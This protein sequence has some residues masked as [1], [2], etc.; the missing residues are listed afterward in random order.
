MSPD[1]LLA[2]PIIASSSNPVHG[3]RRA[4]HENA[5][6]GGNDTPCSATEAQ[7]D[8]SLLAVP[9]VSVLATMK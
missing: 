7:P 6:T 2:H 8:A 4:C 9:T 5:G 3:I 1:I